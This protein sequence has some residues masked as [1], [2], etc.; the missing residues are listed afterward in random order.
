MAASAD[1][2][3]ATLVHETE[4]RIR[5][6]IPDKRGD[7]AYFDAAGRAL[8][9]CPGVRRVSASPLTGSLLILHSGSF[10]SVS[11]FAR[12]QALFQVVPAPPPE[13]FTNIADEMRRLEERLRSGSEQRWGIAGV[14]FYGLVG[15]SIWQAIQGRI[16]PPTVTLLFQAM[17]IFKQASEAESKAR[18]RASS[19]SNG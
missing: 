5:L 1:A 9:S 17:N 10:D 19:S 3:A 4:G 6:R 13:T 8:A 16:L 12:D 15:A 11:S 7:R 14:T 18:A 2:P